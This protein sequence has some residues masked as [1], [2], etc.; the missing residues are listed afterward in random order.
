MPSIKSR[1]SRWQGGSKRAALIDLPDAH[2]K[3]VRWEHKPGMAL[4]PRSSVTSTG[5]FVA[6]GAIFRADPD[7]ITARA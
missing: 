5:K 1:R 3:R 7:L 4:V 2:A 6:D